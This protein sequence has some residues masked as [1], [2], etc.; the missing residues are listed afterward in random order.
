MIPHLGRAVLKRCRPP[1]SMG[2]AGGHIRPTFRGSTTRAGRVVSASDPPGGREAE[3]SIAV[4]EPSAVMAWPVLV[5]VGGER[6]MPVKRRR[7]GD[8]TR[9]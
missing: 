6:K 9:P 4:T 2:L 3:S 1:G 5:I 7:N 8:E